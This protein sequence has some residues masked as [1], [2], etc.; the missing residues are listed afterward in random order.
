MKKMSLIPTKAGY[1]YECFYCKTTMSPV[2]ADV[3]KCKE[4]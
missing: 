3:H 2:D 1:M 4:I